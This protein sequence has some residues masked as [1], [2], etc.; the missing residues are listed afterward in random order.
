[1]LKSKIKQK[2][3][4]LLRWAFARKKFYRLNKILYQL[5]LNGL[6]ILNYENTR[7]SGEY[8]FL[9]TVVKNLDKNAV[10]LDIGA[11][12]GE[13]S[14]SIKKIRPDIQLF[15]FEP[16]PKTFKILEKNAKLHN[17]CAF[18][19]ACGKEKAKLKLYDYEKSNGSQH[20][21]LFHEVIVDIHGS[22]FIEHEIDIINLDSFIKEQN[23]K[24]I[25]FI[26]ID[27]EGN[28]YGVLEGLHEAIKNNL[29][30]IIQFEFN[31]MNVVSRSFFKD[32]YE[33]LSEYTLFRMLPDGIVPLEK[34][35][36]LFCE[37]YAFQN[38]V[39]IHK[40]IKL[41]I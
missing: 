13:Y 21:S 6:G 34:Y 28:E 15:A 24:K 36:P 38:I 40:K 1:M 31:E 12:V 27:V 29:V 25:N 37:I 3:R 35:H 5:S 39:A 19:L 2:I 8:N 7:V 18:N 16:H 22:N 9:T 33:I 26:K 41:H 20:A 11:N 17:Y 4:I 32:F 23:I 14:N 10:V 30:E